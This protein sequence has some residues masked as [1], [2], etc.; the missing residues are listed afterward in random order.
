MTLILILCLMFN[1]VF[2]FIQY[3]KGNHI[4]SHLHAAAAGFLISILYVYNILL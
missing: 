3:D 2:T 1:V 4:M